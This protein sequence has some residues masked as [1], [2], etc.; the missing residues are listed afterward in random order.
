MKVPSPRKYEFDQSFVVVLEIYVSN[1]DKLQVNLSTASSTILF[2]L[3]ISGWS[4][5][6]MQMSKDVLLVVPAIHN[7]NL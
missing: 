4:A 5:Q 6:C 2:A 3:W 1:D 7:T